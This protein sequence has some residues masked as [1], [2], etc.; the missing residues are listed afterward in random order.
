MAELENVMQKIKEGEDVSKVV[1]KTVKK[2]VKSSL[3]EAKK[4]ILKVL[5]TN[6]FYENLVETL[7]EAVDIPFIN[8][9]TEEWVM[10]RL[11]KLIIFSLEKIDF[12]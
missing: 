3:N 9:T 8:E 4:N 5:K 2:T 6:E 10:R 1:K 12:E 7:N 11:V